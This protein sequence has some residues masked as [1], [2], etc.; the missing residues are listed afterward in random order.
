M[1]DGTRQ[2]GKGVVKSVG[3]EPHPPH[4]VY[5]LPD[6]PPSVQ[7]VVVVRAVVAMPK[8]LSL[9]NAQRQNIE[10]FV[11]SRQRYRGIELIFRYLF[12]FEIP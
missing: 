3:E 8:R 2:A 1:V 6:S 9:L 12:G 10:L 4:A 5:H 7:I 11:R